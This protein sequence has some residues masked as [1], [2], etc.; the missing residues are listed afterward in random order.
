MRKTLRVLALLLL[1]VMLLPG[2]WA[3]AASTG[4]DSDADTETAAE[5]P[6]EDSGIIDALALKTMVDNFLSEE[7]IDPKQVSVG[8]CY[9]ATGDTWF[10]NGDKWFYPASM[11]KVPLIMLLAEKV[12]NG[13][14]TQD[15]AIYDSTVG[16][17][18][19]HILTYSN[20][21]WAHIIRKYLGGDSVWREDAKKYASLAE[22]DYH[23]D[24]LDYCYFN[25]RY[26]TSVMK[27]LF[28]ERDRFPNVV[29]CLLQAEPERYFKQGLGG[30][31]EIAQKYGS[32]QDS[33]GEKFN[34]TTAIIYT[35]TPCIVTVMTS[36]VSDYEKLISDIGVELAEYT[37]TLDGQL[38]S[39]LQQKEQEA[40]EEQRRQQEA[41]AEQERQR[42]EQQRLAEE[43][44]KA[45]QEEQR[46]AEAA[47]KRKE[48]LGYV[49][50][51]LAALAVIA[52]FLL[53]LRFVLKRRR[54]EQEEARFARRAAGRPGGRGTRYPDREAWEENTGSS[55]YD[56]YDYGG[57]DDYNSPE[58]APRS[59]RETKS[60][61]ERRRSGKNYTPKH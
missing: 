7:D 3:F 16:Q 28:E 52:V 23:T 2:S 29:E 60:G 58:P 36:N 44:E 19:E 35:P 13:E 47:Q 39:Y 48:I 53:I 15:S 26:M 14:L 27:T 57:Y 12:H 11:Y 9:T 24:Y 43:A 55:G 49:L 42:Q 8:Y 30:Q 32:F 21:D 38:D 50:K 61:P 56:G 10:Y 45:R 46:K 5:L 4:G 40:A 6:V 1:I 41:E 17:V 54:R 34:H 22:A 51:T 20:N 59:R 18:E 31:Y 37:L 33:R 25:N